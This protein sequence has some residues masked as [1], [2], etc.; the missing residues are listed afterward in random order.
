[1]CLLIARAAKVAQFTCS[2][3]TQTREQLHTPVM[4]VT[5]D[6]H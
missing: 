4:P 2:G 6:P 1:M 3:Q 5:L